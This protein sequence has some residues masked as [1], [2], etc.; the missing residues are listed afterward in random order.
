MLDGLGGASVNS[1]PSTRVRNEDGCI[2]LSEKH[3]LQL[4]AALNIADFGLG[5]ERRLRECKL[6][7]PGGS[8]ALKY[9]M[10]TAFN[11]P[12]PHTHSKTAAV[13]FGLL[14]SVLLIK[15][16]SYSVWGR[17]LK[18]SWAVLAKRRRGLQVL[19]I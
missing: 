4:D 3:L 1:S 9:I 16:M 14:S 12:P 15:L 8:G 5:L 10:M 7:S 19:V 17:R 13:C 11:N 2:P 18:F 6:Y